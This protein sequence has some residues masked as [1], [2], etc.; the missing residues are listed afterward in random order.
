MAALSSDE[1]EFP[2]RPLYSPF[3]VA[4]SLDRLLFSLCLP[5]YLDE[6]QT[7]LLF[8]FFHH[9]PSNLLN[10]RHL[11]MCPAHALSPALN[12]SQPPKV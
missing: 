12:S 1:E 8:L 5:P 7:H 4:Y 9:D 2:H 11:P 10:L 3:L 6:P